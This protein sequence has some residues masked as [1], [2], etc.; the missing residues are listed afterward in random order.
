MKFVNDKA[1]NVLYKISRSIKNKTIN[2]LV[3]TVVYLSNKSLVNESII[4][5]DFKALLKQNVSGDIFKLERI[6]SSSPPPPP[7][8]SSPPAATQ[9]S[10]SS[11]QAP[12]LNN[13]N[14]NEVMYKKRK[15]THVKSKRHTP[16][17][18]KSVD[19]MTAAEILDIY[20]KKYNKV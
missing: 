2:D 4:D 10:S 11:S 15:H 12:I 1:V 5:K 17:Q 9:A 18:T 6:V 16:L 14:K 3:N 8:S 19:K 20:R 7:P 13:R